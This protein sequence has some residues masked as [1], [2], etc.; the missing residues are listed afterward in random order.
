MN[1]KKH[2]NILRFVRKIHRW[3]GATLFIIFLFVSVSGLMLGWKKDA[4]ELIMPKTQRG[5][6]KSPEKWLPMDTLATI[7]LKAMQEVDPETSYVIDRMDVRMDRGIV[8]MLMVQ[9]NQEVQLDCATG[10]VLS[11]GTRHSDWIEHVHD[12][13]IIDEWLGIGFFKLLYTTVAGLA[14]F[15]FT[16]TGFWLWYGPKVMRNHKS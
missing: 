13:S 15:L 8:K 2:A 14:L 3:M 1:R 9:K 6:T 5:S 7:S 12:G 11:I 4:G 10:E 16:V